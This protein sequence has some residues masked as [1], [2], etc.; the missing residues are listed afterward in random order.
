[1]AL[2]REVQRGLDRAVRQL[3]IDT[4][5]FQCALLEACVSIGYLSYWCDSR[6][7]FQHFNVIL[8]TQDLLQYF[9]CNNF[10]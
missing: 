10:L 3:C 9:K 1:M 6:E 4:V 2:R 7:K 8:G 5:Q